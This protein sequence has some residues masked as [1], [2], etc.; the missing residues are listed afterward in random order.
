MRI[1]YKKAQNPL[2][3]VQANVRPTELPLQMRE[4]LFEGEDEG[5]GK[6]AWGNEDEILTFAGTKFEYVNELPH[7][8][9]GTDRDAN[10][11]MSFMFME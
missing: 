4:T 5:D 3:N 6:Y 1:L 2:Q 11:T 8:A 10:Q 9:D 7:D